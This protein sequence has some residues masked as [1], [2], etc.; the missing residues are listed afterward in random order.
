[1]RALN[2]LLLLVSVFFCS[3]MSHRQNHSSHLDPKEGSPVRSSRWWF[4]F[5]SQEFRNQA[6]EI[7]H[8][9]RDCLTGVYFYYGGI[10]MDESLN[11]TFPEEE[12]NA[13]VTPFVSLN[14]TASA[15]FGVPQSVIEGRKWNQELLNSVAEKATRSGLYSLMLD[16]EPKSNYSIE[17]AK[18]Y[19]DFVRA[20]AT[21]THS[22]GM[23][24]DMCVS[25]WG[26]LTYYDMYRETNVDAMM[27]M[28]ATYFGNNITANEGWVTKEINQGVSKK[29]LRTG[30]GS[31]N[32]I[33]MK[34]PYNWTEVEFNKFFDFLEDN[35][36]RAVDLWRSDI[37]TLNATNGTA[38]WMTD[39]IRKFLAS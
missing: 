26:I 14:L 25:G 33:S 10:G 15:V 18:A 27:T 12:I 19:A 4:N 29:Q 7:I 30:I 32:S 34:W 31:E 22:Q 17:H 1:M 23:S 24:L 6:L 2:I 9:Y 39:R 38:S 3:A 16:Y 13:V 5:H 35:D 20:F 21:A 36:V 11:V 37:D 28:G 8:K